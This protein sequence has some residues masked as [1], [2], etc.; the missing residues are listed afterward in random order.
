MIM[1]L[2]IIIVH[3]IV[4]C[5]YGGGYAGVSTRYGSSAR[6]VSMGN[7]LVA[8]SNT[9]FNAFSNPSMLGNIK[10][11]EVGSSIFN[12]SQNRN[13]Q[14]ISVCRKLPPSAGA[15]ISFFRSGINNITGI[16]SDEIFT[17]DMGFSEGYIMLSF[18][19]KVSRLL[20]F[21]INGKS[22]FQRYLI[23][24]EEKYLSKGISLD[25]G[26]SSTLSDNLIIGFQCASLF[27]EFNWNQSISS[28]S[29][30]YKEKIP[31]RYVGGISYFPTNKCLM[32]FQFEG[33]SLPDGYLS[34]R[35]SMGFEYSLDVSDNFKPVFFRFGVKQ[36][37]WAELG[38]NE[39]SNLFSPSTGIGLEFDLFD[40]FSLNL[41][42]ALE[43]NERGVN[44]LFSFKTQL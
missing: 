30:P 10:S 22:L 6:E 5:D 24:N 3:S 34:K 19:V 26:L 20:S 42:Y 14:A 13:I 23:S 33:I 25:L 12:L 9:G 11:I 21:G 36:S 39:Q 35:L 18:G 27:G 44:N 28:N 17:G 1:L 8:T 4:F 32:L 29:I 41:D 16:N 7:S 31:R 37:R 15:G 38:E 43:I 40:K 2:Y